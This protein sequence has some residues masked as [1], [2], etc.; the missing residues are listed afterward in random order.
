M[1][2]F[3][4]NPITALGHDAPEVYTIGPW[5]ITERADIALASLAL[6]RGRVGDVVL[7]YLE[8]AELRQDN[9]LFTLSVSRIIEPRTLALLTKD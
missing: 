9:V 7:V 2:D 8:G 5:T 3:I 1:P 4:L 6:L